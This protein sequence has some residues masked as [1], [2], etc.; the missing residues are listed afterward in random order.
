MFV[1]VLHHHDRATARRHPAS[2]HLGH[3]H[4]FEPFF[5]SQSRSS[6]L[7]LYICRELCE[8]YGARLGYQRL[9]RHTAR[10]RIEGNAFTLVFYPTAV[11]GT[12]SSRL[13]TIVV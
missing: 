5:S 11:L 8:R 6:G 10:G 13:D 2:Q 4:L 1:D 9:A 3:R 12:P 7:G